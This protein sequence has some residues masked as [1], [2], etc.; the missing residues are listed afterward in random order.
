MLG[1][2]GMN[3]ARPVPAERIRR[4][5]G[6]WECAAMGPVAGIGFEVWR[7]V[8]LGEVASG[9]WRVASEVGVIRAFRV[10]V[11]AGSGSRGCR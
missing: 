3:S 10:W 4:W 8:G 2:D 5:W 11:R 6:A 9:E 1:A 7:A